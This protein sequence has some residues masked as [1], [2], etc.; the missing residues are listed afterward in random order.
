MITKETQ[1]E[2]KLTAARAYLDCQ[3]KITNLEAENKELKEKLD[4]AKTCLKWHADYG[5]C[6]HAKQAL[7][8]IDN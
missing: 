6:E 5:K 7:D 2:L 4:E 8:K 3:I 1:E